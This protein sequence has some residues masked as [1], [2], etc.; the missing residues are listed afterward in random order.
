[1]I[2][3]S[4]E[5][6]AMAGW[7]CVFQLRA[8]EIIEESEEGKSLTLGD[9]IKHP[10]TDGIFDRGQMI[11]DGIEKLCEVCLETIYSIHPE[12]L[13]IIQDANHRHYVILGKATIPPAKRE[14]AI[15]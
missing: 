12:K 9:F 11:G 1:M 5:A 13:E 7:L 3:S 8:L 14:E 2:V 6:I 10:R 4:Y 15:P